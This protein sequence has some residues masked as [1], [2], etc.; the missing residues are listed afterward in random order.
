MAAIKR[1]QRRL[2]QNP[3]IKQH[4]VHMELTQQH[5]FMR[6]DK[7]SD[8]LR[9]TSNPIIMSLGCPTEHDQRDTERAM[10]SL[11]RE[12]ERC[13]T[14]Q[15][16]KRELASWVVYLWLRRCC[17]GSTVR[18]NRVL[19]RSVMPLLRQPRSRYNSQ[20]VMFSLVSLSLSVSPGRRR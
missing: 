14:P 7:P 8:A 2:E 16:A 6:W 13:T 5:I 17:H 9:S 18:L 11:R 20:G 12:G 4:H 10:N 3:Q 19:A 15:A 1:E